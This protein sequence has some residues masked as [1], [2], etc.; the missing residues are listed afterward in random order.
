[1]TKI[2]Y[3]VYEAIYQMIIDTVYTVNLVE[4]SSIHCAVELISTSKASINNNRIFLY[5]T[6]KAIPDFE[7]IRL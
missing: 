1:M 2:Y 4:E 6:L 3:N 5:V 7:K